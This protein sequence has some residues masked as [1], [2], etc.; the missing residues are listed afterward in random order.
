[1][2]GAF[3]LD[4]R[5]PTNGSGRCPHQPWQRELVLAPHD[6]QRGDGKVAV[7]DDRLIAP[8]LVGIEPLRAIAYGIETAERPIEIGQIGAALVEGGSKE[9]VEHCETVRDLLD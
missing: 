6:E 3:D 8:R 7:V 1:M 9:I 5:R 4:Q 2:T